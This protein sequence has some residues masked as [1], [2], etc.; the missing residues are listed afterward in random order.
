MSVIG[1]RRLRE[2]DKE[3]VLALFRASFGKDKDA[4]QW[5]WEFIDREFP[6]IVILAE[7]DER[8]VGHYAILPREFRAGGLSVPTGLVVDVMTHP[9]YGRKGIFVGSGLEAFRHA[10]DL[11][12]SMLIGFPN[13]AAIKGHLKVGWSELGK[14]RVYARPLSPSGLLKLTGRDRVLATSLGRLLGLLIATL[15]KMTLEA[16]DN[17]LTLESVTPKEIESVNHDIQELTSESL[18]RYHIRNARGADWARWR[19]SDPIGMT[20]IILSRDSDGHEIVGY[21]ILRTK[22]WGGIRTCAIMDVVSKDGNPR[23]TKSLLREAFRRAI[24]NNCELSVMI[25]SPA[26]KHKWLMISMLMLPTPRKLR[27]IVREVGDNRL[28]VE[29]FKL[30][31]WHLELIDHDVF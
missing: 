16:G 11:G 14:I 27:F 19:L 13:D 15:N 22:E 8:I 24:Q 1:Y 4:D 18:K 9:E 29:F 17:G 7:K 3:S 6:A 12:L 2:S 31:C 5:T 30:G 25:D 26:A 23:V 10:K 20:E 28:P 21:C